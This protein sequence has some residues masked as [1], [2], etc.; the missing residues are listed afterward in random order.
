MTEE[1]WRLRRVLATVSMSRSW[2]YEEIAQGRFP[3]PV[4]I[5]LRAVAW[6]RSDIEAWVADRTSKGGDNE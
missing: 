6:R 2:L 5:G 4:R 3:Q 1:L